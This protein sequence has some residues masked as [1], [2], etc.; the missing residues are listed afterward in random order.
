MSPDLTF[1]TGLD[2]LTVL[3]LIATICYAVLLNRK[4]NRLRDNKG[5]MEAVIARFIEA[6][7]HARAGLEGLRDHAS[8][9]GESLQKGL[10]QSSGRIEELAFLIERAESASKRL[11]ESISTARA[12]HAPTEAAKPSVPLRPV[13]PAESGQQAP[14]GGPAPEEASLLK[15]LQGMR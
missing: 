8:E 4:L 6:T 7:D 13:T 1:T 9:S 5:E 14:N 10:T 2:V 11:D 12:S 3:L 15:S